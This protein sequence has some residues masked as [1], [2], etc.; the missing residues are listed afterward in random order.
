MQ[1]I[2]YSEYH[3]LL[4]EYEFEI[5]KAKTQE[6][7]EKAKKRKLDFEN[8]KRENFYKQIAKRVIPYL[9]ECK[10]AEL[11][12]FTIEKG[13]F[14]KSVNMDFI[15]LVLQNGVN[16]NDF[17]GADAKT[18]ASPLDTDLS[19]VMTP[20]TP[21]NDMIDAK[22]QDTGYFGKAYFILKNNPIK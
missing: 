1:K 2:S 16:A 10:Y 6:D 8:R 4:E 21:I 14:I 5:K 12:K 3:K 9:L 19:R 7:K 15:E 17:L 11:E 13:D 20:K 22:N 18:D